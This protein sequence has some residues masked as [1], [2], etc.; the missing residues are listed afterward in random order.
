MLVSTPILHVASS[1]LE[2]MNEKGISDRITIIS[3]AFWK[4]SEW[5]V[6]GSHWSIH[7]NGESPLDMLTR[8]LTHGTRKYSLSKSWFCPGSR[9]PVQYSPWLLVLSLGGPFLSIVPIDYMYI[10]WGTG[11]PWELR[12]SLDL[13]LGYR[14]TRI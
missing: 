12:S 13:L 6:H 3:R 8:I 1:D 9:C 14:N 7:N 2:I 4:R 5:E 11:S 10:P